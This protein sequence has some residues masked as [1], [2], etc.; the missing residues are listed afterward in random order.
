MK[1]YRGENT[2]STPASA[3]YSWTTDLNVANFFAC[4]RG[5]GPASITEAVV[6]KKDIIEA[7][8]DDRD[9]SEVIVNPRNVHI[10]QQIPVHGLDF[11]TPILPEIA[12]MFHK[13]MEQ[14]EDIAFAQNSSIHGMGHEARVLLLSLTLSH[15]LDLPSRDRKILATAAIFHDSQRTNDDTDPTH[16]KSGREYYHN[17]V[18]SPDP[19]VEFLCEFHCLPDDVAYN[20]IRN[21]RKLSKHRSRAKLLF[22]I[23]K[24]AD[25]L[26]RVRF[27]IR[28]LDL[29]QLRL[30]ISK[31]LTLVARLYLEQVKIPERHFKPLLSNQIQTASSRA[32]NAHS[33]GPS[34]KYVA[35]P[36]R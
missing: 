15:L 33:S 8:F 30:P 14:M 36:D 32:T 26:D 23:F 3:A 7:F 34:K 28:D 19:L 17:F 5:F 35:A 16:G 9:E 24:D 21:N 10:L 2:A 27:D 20:E 6:A 29:N 25:A 12:P 4:R 22:D 13:Y 31:E 18:S 11:L 1:I